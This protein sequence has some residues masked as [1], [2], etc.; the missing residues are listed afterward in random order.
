M[1]AMFVLRV[2]VQMR[3]LKFICI[4]TLN[5]KFMYNITIETT[6]TGPYRSCTALLDI[7]NPLHQNI[8]D[9]SNPSKVM[10]FKY[11]ANSVSVKFSFVEFGR[12]WFG[13]F[14]WFGQVNFG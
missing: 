5:N 13:K 7:S 14:G 3:P 4:L 10:S 6:S 11:L 2:L 8:S 9:F 12:F 1:S